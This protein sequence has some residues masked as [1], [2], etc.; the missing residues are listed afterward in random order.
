[1]ID[2]YKWA[3]FDTHTLSL[4]Q[5]VLSYSER[6]N[7]AGIGHNEPLQKTDPLSFQTLFDSR[8]V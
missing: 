2:E 5:S 6:I 1:M 4:L 3:S 8:T 7:G